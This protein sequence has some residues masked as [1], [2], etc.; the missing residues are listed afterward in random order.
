MIRV[1]TA[2]RASQMANNKGRAEG[3]RGAVP[4]EAEP[5]CESNVL[6]TGSSW[7][8]ACRRAGAGSEA[9]CAATSEAVSRRCNSYGE[10]CGTGPSRD[11]RAVPL[12]LLQVCMFCLCGFQSARL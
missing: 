12:H 6:L 1:A 4:G 9:I 5:L 2:F 3:V 10:C 8:T 11:L 7:V